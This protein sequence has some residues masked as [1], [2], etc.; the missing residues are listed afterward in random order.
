MTLAGGES[1]LF[2]ARRIPTLQL[3][4]AIPNQDLT[5]EMLRERRERLARE[6]ASL[7]QGPPGVI[8]ARELLTWRTRLAE[9]EARIARAA[10]G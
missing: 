7:E 5:L 1:R 4:S 2:E 10:R 9:L 8:S 3:M 6:L